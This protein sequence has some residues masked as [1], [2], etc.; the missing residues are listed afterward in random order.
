M[1]K[2]FMVKSGMRALLVFIT[3]SMAG[4]STISGWFTDDEELE[5]RT[6]KP[7]EAA[8]EPEELW[9]EDV[10][11]GVENYYSLLRPTMGYDLLFAASRQ[12]EITAFEP[13][14]GK[15]VWSRDFATYPNDGY[16][17]FISN[18]WSD[19]VSAKISG[20]LTVAYE[21]V[22]FG[23]EDGDVYAIDAKTGETK[24]R[25]KIKGEV[26][27]AP[28]VDEGVL[29]VNTGSGVL[30][31]L[32]TVSGEELWTYESDVPALSLRGI[33]PP[34]AANGGALVGTATGKLAVVLLR[35]GQVA[36]EQTISAP[37]G[38][39]EL[40]RI[41]DI[42]SQPLVL[43]GTIFTVSF[44]GT[45]AAVEMRTGRVIWKREYKSYR[46]I[47]V[48]GNRL[49]VVDTN[50]HVYS[51]D[52]RNG[53]EQWSQNAL[54]RRVLTAV[55]PVGEYLVAGDKY[56]FLHWFNQSDGKIVARM[57]I[58]GDDEDEAIY[59]TPVAK[60]NVIYTMTREGELVAIETP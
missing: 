56:G 30:F 27:A 60:D 36:W 28:A 15:E 39:T 34:S 21:S 35:S 57:D 49:F 41:V 50:S 13:L 44:D 43:G 2:R 23:T 10:G 26:I 14:T 46:S 51:L 52:R 45:L 11:N 4:C 29:V 5:I 8:F 22:F 17:S 53:V 38:A 19:G 33:S 12:G 37:S 58:G 48:S 3:L 7:I 16:L 20:G 32:D 1:A 54:N 59:T 55:E 24:W 47:S 40:D 42:D 18:L 31:A 6:L 25:V 9:S